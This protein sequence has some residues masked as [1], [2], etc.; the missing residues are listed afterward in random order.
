METPYLSDFPLCE[1]ITVTD[2]ATNTTY[3]KDQVDQYINSIASGMLK[4]GLPPD[5]R[6][7]VLGKVSIHFLA[8]LLAMYR[9]RYTTVPV[10]FKVPPVQIEYCL[11]DSDCRMV[12]CDPELRHLVPDGYKCIEFGSTDFNSLLDHSDY[13]MPPFD[14][15]KLAVIMYTSGTTGK[16]KGVELTFKSRIWAITKGTRLEQVKPGIPHCSSIHVSP[17]Y[18]LAGMNNIDMSTMHSTHQTNHLVL[19]P[20]FNAREYIKAIEKYQVT[21]IRVVSP[22]MSMILQEVDLLKTCKLDSV[23]LIVLTS[24]AAPVKM[25]NTI[26]EYFT[27]ATQIENPYGLTE[28]GS[29]FT[30]R[31][32]LGI[33]RPQGSVGYP[34]TNAQVRIVDGV[35][36]VKSP[37]MLVGYYKNQDLYNDKLTDDGFFITGD[38]FRCNKYGFYFYMG[39]ADDMFKSGGE[40]IYPH[41]IETVMDTCSDVALSCVV[42]VPDDIKGHKPYAFVQL[43]P[44]GTASAQDIKEY[45]IKN[46]ATYQIP[47]RVWILDE[48]PKTNIGKIDRRALT[49]L[50]QKLLDEEQSRPL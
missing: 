14:E 48:L 28:T 18:H 16:P 22:M 38:L 36:Q 9:C 43:K 5:A 27:G 2:L 35:L 45:T 39:R 3:N 47:R 4:L 49:E 15:N 12:F 23:S 13:V 46:V 20:D 37:S 10:N 50:A 33:P 31:H 42:G 41:E 11:A 30:P 24:A 17:I 29:I 8:F 34:I 21:T 19:M 26:R 44:D 40:K 25:Q 32:P 6:I 7:A 1:G